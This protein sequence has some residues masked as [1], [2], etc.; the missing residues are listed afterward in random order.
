M[1]TYRFLFILAVAQ[2]FL[3]CSSY[4]LK[5]V[6]GTPEYDPTGT[7]S[8]TP[9]TGSL[10]HITAYM[11]GVMEISKDNE[12]KLKITSIVSWNEVMNLS[13]GKKY[14]Q[15]QYE[16]NGGTIQT[17]QNEI[18]AEKMNI[19]IRNFDY[20]GKTEDLTNWDPDKL[21]DNQIPQ[22]LL[23]NHRDVHLLLV[24]RDHIKM[25]SFDFRNGMDFYKIQD[26]PGESPAAAKT[27]NKKSSSAKL[28][29]SVFLIQTDKSIITFQSPNA[30]KKVA[31][32]SSIIIVRNNKT[33]ARGN[34]MEVYSNGG[35]VK[36]SSG[37]KDIQPRDILYGY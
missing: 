24:D 8:L 14:M 3:S 23:G 10:G 26:L 15:I 9:G 21:K 25:H 1:K 33:I 29:G 27:Q 30:D 18:A 4:D 22:P 11:H 34:L 16:Y 28:K 2:F 32:G 35:K 31:K 6:P 36:I 19:I 5:N 7:W 20:M 37:F 13:N 17:S 12:N